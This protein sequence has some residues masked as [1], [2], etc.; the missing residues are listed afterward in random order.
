M[1]KPTI[2]ILLLAFGATALRADLSYD[3]TSKITHL[4]V[5]GKAMCHR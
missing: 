5:T 1:M 4:A 2:A 3:Q